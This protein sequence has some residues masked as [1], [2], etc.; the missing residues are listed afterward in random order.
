MVGRETDDPA[1]TPFAICFEQPLLE[2]IRTAVWQ[3][4]GKIIGK[5]KGIGVIGVLVAACPGITGAQ[6]TTGVMRRPLF[7]RRLFGFTLPGAL[8]AMGRHE[9]PFPRKDIVAAVRVVGKIKHRLLF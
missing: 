3:E 8:G 5:N 6:I 9:H 1:Y 2:A 7:I 4:G